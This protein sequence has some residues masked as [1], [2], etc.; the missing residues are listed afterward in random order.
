[1]S[2]SKSKSKK[3]KKTKNIFF[4]SES[5]RNKVGRKTLLFGSKRV[6]LF[7]ALIAIASGAAGLAILQKSNDANAATLG[8]QYG[9]V[10]GGDTNRGVD[11]AAS[12]G[13]NLARFYE[14]ERIDSPSILDS[15][16]LNAVTK[17]VEPLLLVDDDN[18]GR[19]AEAGNAGEIAARFGPGG[20]FWQNGQPGAGYGQ[21]APRW[22]EWGNETSYSYSPKP[23]L[24]GGDE[25]AFSAMSAAQAM[26]TANPNMGLIIQ[27][28]DGDSG[29]TRWLDLVFTATPDINSWVAGWTVHPYGP[30]TAR[31]D[32]MVTLLSQKGV[33][34]A[35]IFITE[36]GLAT[37][38]GNT[39]SNN[40]GWPTNMTYDQ[41][42]ASINQKVAGIKS[43]SYASRVRTYIQYQA[44]DQRA[45]GLTTEREHYFGILKSDGTDKGTYTSTVRTLASENPRDGTIVLNPNTYANFTISGQT[46]N[47]PTIPYITS[48]KVYLADTKTY[49]TLPPNITSYTVPPPA[50]GTQRKVAWTWYDGKDHWQP[51]QTVNFPPPPPTILE[52][53]SSGICASKTATFSCSRNLYTDSTAVGSK[54]VYLS[55]MNDNIS[56]SFN[57]ATAGTHRIGYTLKSM[58]YRGDATVDL[59][60]DN[61]LVSKTISI[62]PTSYA[63][64]SVDKALQPGQHT[65]KIVFTNDKCGNTRPKEVCS[66]K[67]DRNLLID[68]WKQSQL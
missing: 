59:Y 50:T 22:L 65:V 24:E 38:N 21:F 4:L 52:A 27:G 60:I 10:T 62:K 31:M 30:T 13:I 58:S 63:Y 48:Y 3:S 8:M 37:D 55:S 29:S 5:Q 33:A 25:Y 32:R 34:S 46:M 26:R 17:G 64:Y 43:K 41:A 19:T 57:V 9:I 61:V 54:S 23:G 53:E 47:W 7:A 36:D 68:Q 67:Y 18:M 16:V 1:M 28:E 66:T 40:Y 20:T 51:Q 14:I 11:G 15:Q 44:H 2:I 42:S 6:I 35:P 12:L 39:L 49:I 45:T 56:Q